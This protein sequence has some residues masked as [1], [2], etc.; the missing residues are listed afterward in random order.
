MSGSSRNVEYTS[1]SFYIFIYIHTHTK[2]DINLLYT[3]MDDNN[4]PALS[5][6]VKRNEEFN[7]DTMFYNCLQGLC[8]AWF[9][10]VRV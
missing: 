6:Q 5:L 8:T 4:F 2:P 3:I 1:L 7:P 10:S 9:Q